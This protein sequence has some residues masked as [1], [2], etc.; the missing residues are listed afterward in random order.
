MLTVQQTADL[1]RS[2][3]N[4]LILTH[5]RPDG[6]TVGCAAALC[7]GLRHLGKTAYL[8]PNPGLTDTTAPYAA[9]YA[10]PEEFLPEEAT[11]NLLWDRL[12]EN[13]RP[14]IQAR[15]ASLRKTV[16]DSDD[17]C[18]RVTE[19]TD[20][21]PETLTEADAAVYPH[22]NPDISHVQQI[23]QY[24]VRRMELLDGIFLTGES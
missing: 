3:D 16:F 24:I 4:I 20:A 12:A 8:L 13:F 18:R 22:P 9:H 1:L 5:V 23:T 7:A 15:Y 17:L 11:G 19:Y 10:A 14:E 6:D 2:F 21:I